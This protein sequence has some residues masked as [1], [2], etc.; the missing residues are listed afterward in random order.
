MAKNMEER[1]MRGKRRHSYK[2]RF[3]LT[4]DVALAALVLA[5]D[6]AVLLVSNLVLLPLDLTKRI[7]QRLRPA[8][9][10]RVVR[11]PSTRLRRLA[12]LC[13]SKKVYGLVFEPILSDLQVEYFEALAEGDR[14][15]AR[16]ALVRGYWAFW[17]AVGAQLPVSLFRIVFEMWKA[18]KIG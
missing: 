2:Q 14:W 3:H 17:T 11:A 12:E 18:T 16:F 10:S 7:R 1:A 15:K 9:Y 4:K 13:F 6:S 8:R 5:I